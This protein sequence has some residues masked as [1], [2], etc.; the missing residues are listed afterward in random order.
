[1]SDSIFEAKLAG[2]NLHHLKTVAKHLA[3]KIEAAGAPGH[4]AVIRELIKRLDALADEMIR[5]KTGD[6]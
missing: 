1:M 5:Q 4:A 3:N 6:A 2:Y